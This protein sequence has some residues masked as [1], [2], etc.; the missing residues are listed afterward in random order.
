LRLIE[1]ISQKNLAQVVGVFPTTIINWEKDRHKPARKCLRKLAKVLNPDPKQFVQYDGVI[2]NRQKRI[3]EFLKQQ[4]TATQ[5]ECGQAL[6][7]TWDLHRDLSYLMDIGVVEREFRGN[8][9]YYRL[10]QP[11]Q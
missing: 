1:G 7:L 3:L 10:C 4:E 2:C 9:A 8:T 5:K 6:N 11:A